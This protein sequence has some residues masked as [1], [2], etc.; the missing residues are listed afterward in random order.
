[1]TFS[2]FVEITLMTYLG[3][4]HFSNYNNLIEF[5][6]VAKGMSKMAKFQAQQSLHVILMKAMEKGE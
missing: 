2:V 1:M 5:C 6:S 3:I 4:Q